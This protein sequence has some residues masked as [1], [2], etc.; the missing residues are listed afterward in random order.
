M[1]DRNR[2]FTSRMKYGLGRTLGSN[3]VVEEPP[4]PAAPTPSPAQADVNVQPSVEDRA[5]PEISSVRC[6][7]VC[8]MPKG[9]E[10]SRVL[11]DA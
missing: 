8:A 7:R 3:T 2:G 10:C 9:R 5:L 1:G 11:T 4:P 6:T